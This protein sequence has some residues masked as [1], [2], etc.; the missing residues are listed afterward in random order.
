MST[1]NSQTSSSSETVQSTSAE[2]KI[3]PMTGQLI[4][5]AEA[6]SADNVRRALARLRAEKQKTQKE[7]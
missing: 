4:L 3:Y 5:E 7:S 6:T 1:Q 2:R